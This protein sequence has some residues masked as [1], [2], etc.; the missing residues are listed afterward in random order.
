MIYQK[1]VKKKYQ[2]DHDYFSFKNTSKQARQSC[3]SFLSK[4]HKKYI[5]ATSIFCLSKLGW[6]KYMEMKPIHRPSKLYRKKYVETMLIFAPSKLRKQSMYK[7]HWFFVLQNYV[8]RLTSIFGQSKFHR[9]GTSKWHCSS[10]IFSFRPIDVIPTLN[11]SWFDVV[12]QL[13]N[14]VVV[15]S[16]PVLPCSRIYNS[17]EWCII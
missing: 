13:G 3:Y 9:K 4:L 16:F 7:R 12:C 8:V 6:K 15:M 11:Q 2:N 5:K 10:S 14:I 1:L 17:L